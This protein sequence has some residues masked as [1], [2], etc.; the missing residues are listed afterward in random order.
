MLSRIKT[1]KVERLS[2]ELDET[3]WIRDVPSKR[4]FPDLIH[5]ITKKGGEMSL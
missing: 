5:V 3:A 1:H 2:L 4:S